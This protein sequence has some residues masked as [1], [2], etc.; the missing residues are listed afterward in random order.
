MEWVKKKDFTEYLK[1]ATGETSSSIYMSEEY[2]PAFI[3][4]IEAPTLKRPM[5]YKVKTLSL[6]ER[7]DRYIASLSKTRLGAWLWLEQMAS[8]HHIQALPW[9]A[10]TLFR[11]LALKLHP[12]HSKDPGAAEKFILLQAKF[13][14]FEAS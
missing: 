7:K 4:S 5:G 3:F 8:L 2:V 10:K 6:E 12:D 11:K 13:K 9:D 1:E 14:I